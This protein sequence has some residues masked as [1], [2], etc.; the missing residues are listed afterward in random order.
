VRAAQPLALVPHID[1]PARP[2]GARS[3]R[4]V[5]IG[6]LLLE[7]VPELASGALEIVDIAREASLLQ[8][9]GPVLRFVSPAAK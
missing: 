4:A 2:I 6:E 1:R 9:G 8:Q 7:H 3:K 5:S